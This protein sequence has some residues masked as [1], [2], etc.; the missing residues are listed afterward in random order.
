MHLL[1]APFSWHG[2]LTVVSVKEPIGKTEGTTTLERYQRTL[3]SICSS[4]GGGMEDLC[5]G[6]RYMLTA[7]GD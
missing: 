5:G 4:V 3:D 2:V 1:R 6:L 7:Q